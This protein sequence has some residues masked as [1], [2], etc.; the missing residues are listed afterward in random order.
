LLFF[1]H[2]RDGARGVA[3]VG[4]QIAERRLRLH[5]QRGVNQRRLDP[6]AGAERGFQRID[7]DNPDKAITALDDIAI[8][9][10]FIL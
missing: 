4:E 3:D 9:P 10:V 1:I 2:H 7:R 6:L 5:R 8:F